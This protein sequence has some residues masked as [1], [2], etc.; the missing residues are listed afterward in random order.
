[1]YELNLI[2]KIGTTKNNFLATWKNIELWI[3]FGTYKTR[4][5]TKTWCSIISILLIII[6]II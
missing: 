3:C 5:R 2:Q 4:W 6:V 1:M